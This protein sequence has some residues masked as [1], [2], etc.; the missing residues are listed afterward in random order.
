MA[1]SAYIQD[2]RQGNTLDYKINYG[3]GFDITD[4]KFTFTLATD[5]EMTVPE[6]EFQTTVGDNPLD[7]PLN[8][9]VYLT[10]SASLTDILVPGKY[11]WAFKR[12]DAGTPE[13]EWTILPPAS[14]YKDMVR[15]A[16]RVSTL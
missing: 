16:P 1:T 12:A 11:Y 15:V 6:L 9:L 10:I 7:D 13:D 8:G 14:A 2:I 3:T 5:F 4:W